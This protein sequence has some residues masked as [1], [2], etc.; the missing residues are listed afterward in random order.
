MSANYEAA[1]TLS[2]RVPRLPTLKHEIKTTVLPK[3]VDIPKFWGWLWWRICFLFLYLFLIL[4]LWGETSFSCNQVSFVHIRTCMTYALHPPS[5]P[6]LHQTVHLST[7]LISVFK[8]RKSEG[9]GGWKVIQKKTLSIN[10]LKNLSNKIKLSENKLDINFLGW[11]APSRLYL[12]SFFR[13]F[14]ADVNLEL[15][16]TYHFP[17]AGNCLHNNCLVSAVLK[18]CTRI[19]GYVSEHQTTSCYVSSSWGA[20]L[21]KMIA[22]NNVFVFWMSWTS[23]SIAD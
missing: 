8:L 12:T 1:S 20:D 16:N 21:A 10:R 22:K 3:H 18:L 15:R 17:S 23:V 19:K 5:P 6:P 13:L 14:D 11:K 4:W 9:G 7:L 2:T